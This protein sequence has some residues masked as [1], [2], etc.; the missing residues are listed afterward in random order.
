MWELQRCISSPSIGR[1]NFEGKSFWVY[2][3]RYFVDI[4]RFLFLFLSLFL[5]FFLFCLF[6][7]FFVVQFQFRIRIDIFN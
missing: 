3:A 5:C 1:E 4:S 7:F 6:C 2:F